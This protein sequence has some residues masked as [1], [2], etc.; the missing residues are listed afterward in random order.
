MEIKLQFYAVLI[1]RLV[2]INLLVELNFKFDSITS[3]FQFI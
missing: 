1:T 2:A 3:V